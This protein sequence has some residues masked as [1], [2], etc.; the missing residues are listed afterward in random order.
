[1]KISNEEIASL[2]SILY[3]KGDV[4]TTSHEPYAFVISSKNRLRFCE[5]CFGWWVILSSWKW[6]KRSFHNLYIINTLKYYYSIKKNPLFCQSCL[7]VAY[8]STDCK[9]SDA[10]N[11]ENECEMLL[12]VGSLRFFIDDKVRLIARI[13]TRMKV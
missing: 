10:G 9:Y 13:W 11:H 6:L 4:I 2:E 8:C 1:M 7:C 12:K 5:S 3:K